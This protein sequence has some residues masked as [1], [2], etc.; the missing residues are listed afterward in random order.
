MGYLRDHVG[1]EQVDR[2]GGKYNRTYRHWLKKMKIRVERRRAK[3]DP[4][5]LPAYRKHRGYM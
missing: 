2:A 1:C 3:N 4:E 5:C